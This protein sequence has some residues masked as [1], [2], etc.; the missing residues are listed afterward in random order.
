[1]NKNLVFTQDV[2]CDFDELEKFVHNVRMEIG[3]GGEARV[4]SSHVFKVSVSL[5]R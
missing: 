4:S 2:P 1:M 3:P 5:P